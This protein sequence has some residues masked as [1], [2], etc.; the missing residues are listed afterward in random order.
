MR[1]PRRVEIHA[2]R[3]E[4][5]CRSYVVVDPAS[6]D[7]AVV[8]PLLTHVRET[9]DAIQERRAKV[10]WIVDTHP[11]GDHLSG[12]AAL[13][14]RL[15]AEVILHPDFESDVA[16]IR[17]DDG[18]QFPLG[19]HAMTI[20]HAPGLSPAAVVVEVPG[21]LMT[22]DSLLIGTVGI[23]DTKGAD[24]DDWFASLERIFA[25]RDD[26]TVIHPGHDDMGRSM[27]TLRAERTGNRW[28][29]ED[30][31]EAFRSLFASDDRRAA[32]EADRI[33]EANRGGLSKVPRELAAY[34]GF[35][36][37]VEVENETRRQERAPLESGEPLPRAPAAERAGLLVLCGT[38]AA[39]GTIAGWLWHPGAHGASL[40]AA[41]ILLATGLPGLESRRKRRARLRGD[42]FYEGA[43]PDVV[44]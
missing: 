42:L 13:R 40:L 2:I 37:P 27:T 24:A 12:A 14:Q 30:D 22:G 15:G 7:A 10:R 36:S 25:D 39:A 29:R 1:D 35:R 41:L 32:K 3:H 18:Q 26:E 19:E 16:T 20:H 23:R 11:H 43:P 44:T 17:A 33:L 8:D 6:R 5:G 38:L 4:R 9:L 28:L 31:L 34:A 21:A